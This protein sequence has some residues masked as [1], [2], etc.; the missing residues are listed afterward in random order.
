MYIVG[1]KKGPYFALVL[2]GRAALCVVCTGRLIG[3]FPVVLRGFFPFP[4]RRYNGPI[5]PYL[6]SLQLSLNSFV[7]FYPIKKCRPAAI[8]TE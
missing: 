1:E 4:S 6:M 7:E 2:P 3:R 5:N 8:V